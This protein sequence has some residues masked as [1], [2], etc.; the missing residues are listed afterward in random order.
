MPEQDAVV[1]ITSGVKDMQGVLNLVWDD[2][3]PAMKA[4]PLPAD[5]D[6]DA[7]L[8]SRLADLALPTQKGSA[9][10]RIPKEVSGKKFAFPANDQKVETLGL[11]FGA[12]GSG[13]TLVGTF[14]GGAEQRV[15]C[16]DGEWKKGRLAFG[17]LPEQPAAVSG[18]WTA[19]DV[20]TA[21]VCFYETPY[22]ITLRLDFSGEKLRMDSTWNVSFGPTKQEPLVGERK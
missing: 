18:A 11:E 15:A 19:D 3:L 16:G 21:K 13:V 9:S 4:E 17:K 5:D 2:L 14:N 22:L 10:A 7:K 12:D 6:G 8:R 1:A 20:Y